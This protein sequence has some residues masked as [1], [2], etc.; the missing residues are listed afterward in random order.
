MPRD[1]RVPVGRIERD[2]EDE[3]TFH[4]ESRVADLIARGQPEETARRHAEAEFGDLRASRRELAAVDRHRHRRER[5][6]CWLDA[7]A[8][9]LRQAA[10]SLRRS[11]AFTLAAVLTLVIG[12][13]SSAAIFAVV[14]G[15][16]KLDRVRRIVLGI[17]RV[18]VQPVRLEGQA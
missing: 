17:E 18:L 7:T 14:N 15:V 9:D 13:G 3:I 5:I 8:R 12:I 1:P 16:R 4:L 11:P 10:R 2:V 6:A